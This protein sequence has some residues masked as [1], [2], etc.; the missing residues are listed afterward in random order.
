VTG[1]AR[2]PDP[3]LVVASAAKWA[4]WLRKN[5]ARSAGVFLRIPKGKGH[6]LT[7]LAA[8]EA[9]LAWGWIDSQIKSLDETAYLQRFTPRT[10]RSPWSKTNC[11]RAE[12]LIAAGRMET[13]G[14]AHVESAKRDGRWERAYEGSRTMPV[15]DDL[16]AA[17]RRNARA[18]VF[19]EQL[20]R[21]NRYAILHRIAM[22]K[23][24]ATR[25]RRI[26]KFVEMC[27]AHETLHPRSK[28]R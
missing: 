26:A 25:A 2:K 15:P 24:P 5:H 23:L 27:A 8:V 16:T 12:A 3:I 6:S 22:A 4:A 7:Y 18:R 1:V 20:D 11:A 14:L 19:F 28:P 9:A 21:A 10:T 13:P 17:L